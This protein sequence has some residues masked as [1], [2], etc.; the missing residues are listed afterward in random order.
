V[1][2]QTEDTLPED[3]GMELNSRIGPGTSAGGARLDKGNEFFIRKAFETD[4]AKGYELLFKYYYEPLC[5][6]AVRFV[7]NKQ[8]AEDIVADVFFTIW[9]KQLHDHISISFR[10]YLFTSVRNKC[11][12][13][14]KWELD[15]EKS[16]DLDEDSISSALLPDRIMEL[17]ELYLH[18]EKAIN[19]FPPQCQK[20]FLMSRFEGKSYQEIASSLGIS[21]KAVEA[22]IS[23]ALGLLRKAIH[24]LLVSAVSILEL[25]S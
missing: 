22:H 17:D 19:S 7:Y 20:V 5:S 10:A 13:Y 25:V 18:L 1:G 3:S 11:L 2:E 12:T 8:V 4:S 23:K 14:L 6:H 16:E 9:N 15:K 21:S 24:H